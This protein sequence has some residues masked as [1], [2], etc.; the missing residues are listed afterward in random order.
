M[1]STVYVYLYACVCVCVCVC[2][3]YVCVCVCVCVCVWCVCVHVSVYSVR[4]LMWSSC[5]FLPTV[6]TISYLHAD[7][8]LFVITTW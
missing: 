6:T 8:P 2:F 5:V 3:V 1:C 4:T 7:T